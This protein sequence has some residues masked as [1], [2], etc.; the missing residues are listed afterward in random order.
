MPAAQERPHPRSGHPRPHDIDRYVGGRMRERRILLGLT[1]HQ[2]AELIGVTYQQTYKY[3]AGINRIAAGRLSSI[4]RALDVDVGY[5]FDGMDSERSFKPTLHQR[6][7]VDL[8]RNFLSM[9]SRQHQEVICSLARTL[10][11]LKAA[12]AG[13]T[14][15]AITEP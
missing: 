4:A 2:L 1:Q 7:L 6:M 13:D 3:E 15:D 12:P 5:F 9:P 14:V 8:A 11:N 10:A